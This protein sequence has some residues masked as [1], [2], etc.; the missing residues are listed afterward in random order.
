MEL[1]PV[2]VKKKLQ[3]LDL[4]CGKTKRFLNGL[5]KFYEF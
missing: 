2:R 5:E 4:K 3:I 1:T